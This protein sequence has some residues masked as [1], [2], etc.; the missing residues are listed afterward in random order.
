MPELPEVETVVRQLRPVLIGRKVIAL[1]ILDSKLDTPEKEAVSGRKILAVQR[2][3]KQIA[4]TLS[5]VED[6]AGPLWLVYHLRMSG[7]LI[8]DG[9]QHSRSRK[10]LRAELILDRGRLFFYDVRRFGLLKIFHSL[11]EALPK[12]VDPLSSEFTFRKLKEM[13]ENSKQEIKPWLLR[14]SLP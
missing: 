14:S 13:L 3:G 6:E 11:E 2:L 7:R 1:N 12:G 8:W 4:L 10:Y 9:D 5:A